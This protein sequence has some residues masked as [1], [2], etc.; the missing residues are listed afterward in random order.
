V[1][2]EGERVPELF[3]EQRIGSYQQPR[4]TAT[5]RF[6]TTRVYVVPEGKVEFEYWLRPTFNR[7]AP[8]P[9]EPEPIEPP[10]TAIVPPVPVRAQGVTGPEAQQSQ[11]TSRLFF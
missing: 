6:P 11:N 7:D 9:A 5:R 3:E 8:A 10:R 4:W 1:T 2:V